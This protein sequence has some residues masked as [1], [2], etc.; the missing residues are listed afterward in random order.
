MT[1]VPGVAWSALAILLFTALAWPAS[2]A[3][4][5][6]LTASDPAK[7]AT[8]GTAP[9]AVTLSFT[10]TPDVRLTTIKVLDSSG[11]N[12]TSGPV[13]VVAGDTLSVAVPLEPLPDG[14]YT[15]SWR[16]VSAVDGHISAGSFVFGI[17]APPPS[18]A[19]AEPEAPAS[20]SGSP[21]AVGAR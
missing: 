13:A 9:A 17:G 6:R 21:P 1:R 10:E 18:A 15:V 11:A 7:G 19:P 16:T 12:R 20:I 14:A 2:V 3:A 5:A 4:H 8:V